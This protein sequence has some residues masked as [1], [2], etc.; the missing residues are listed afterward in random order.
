[1]LDQVNEHLRQTGWYNK[2]PPDG[3]EIVFWYV[4][5]GIVQVVTLPVPADLQEVNRVVEQKRLGRLSQ[6]ILPDLRLQARL[7]HHSTSSALSGAAVRH[8]LAALRL[9]ILMAD[10]PSPSFA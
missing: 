2:F 1:M 10:L 9:G 4:M 7:G 8:L 5:M 6:G 3:V